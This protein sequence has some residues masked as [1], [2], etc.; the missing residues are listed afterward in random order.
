SKETGKG[1][2]INTKF[3]MGGDTF[4]FFIKSL[5]RGAYH[6]VRNLLIVLF[7]VL[8]SFSITLFVWLLFKNIDEQKTAKNKIYEMYNE[9]KQKQYEINTIIENNPDAIIRIGKDGEIFQVN[10]EFFRIVGYDKN[11][12]YP[13][14]IFEYTD[15]VN[16]DKLKEKIENLV[17]E[18]RTEKLFGIEVRRKD[19]DTA[20]AEL[21]IIPIVEN[22]ECNYLWIFARDLTEFNKLEKKTEQQ[23]KMEAIGNVTGRVAHDFNNVLTGII[24]YSDMII[25]TEK[26]DGTL[27]E[28]ARNIKKAGLIAKNL[29]KDLLQFSRKQK[30]NKEVFD[31]NKLIIEYVNILKGSV[32][33]DILIKLKLDNEQ[34]IISADKNKI[35]SVLLNLIT[36]AIDSIERKGIIQIKTGH[37]I[38]DDNSYVVLTIED[39][40]KGIP[41]D[42]TNRIFEPFFTTKEEGKGTGLGLSIVYGIIDQHNGDISVKSKL[43]EGTV[44]EIVLPE[45]KTDPEKNPSI[46]DR[47]EKGTGKI[48]LVDN[49]KKSLDVINNMLKVLGYNVEP[50]DSP[51]DALDIYKNAPDKYDLVVADYMMPDINGLEMLKM[52]RKINPV[53]K[54]TII[55]GY[56]DDNSF[57]DNNEF[58]ILMK[59]FTM[60]ELSRII[61]KLLK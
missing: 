39:N 8:L 32:K 15:E 46:S 28:Y 22:P 17:I 10:E 44:F 7:G 31:L 30:L 5:H 34:C 54:A 24:G 50:T 1:K 55:S 59:P 42:I 3:T 36:N 53:L 33:K 18:K 61:K 9:L 51:R 4:Y 41:D 57:L 21:S 19:G 2:Y 11:N 56:I 52:M 49:D 38:A 13:G 12:K 29:I 20:V 37:K 45:V 35:E 58:V 26:A 14:N 60:E 25:N 6:N 43:N 40:G 48:L 27:V 47:V 16:R 23:T